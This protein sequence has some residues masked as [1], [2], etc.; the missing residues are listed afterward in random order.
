MKQV[1]HLEI[2]LDADKRTV[3]AILVGN[4]YTV[5]TATVMAGNRKRSV[6]EVWKDENKKENQ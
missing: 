1:I 2:S 6:I 3:A 4:G 5:R